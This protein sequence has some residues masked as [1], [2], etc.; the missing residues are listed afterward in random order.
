MSNAYKLTEIAKIIQ[1]KWLCKPKKEILITD[2]L[3]DSRKLAHTDKTLFFALTGQKLDGHSY[4]H[5]LYEKGVRAFVVSQPVQTEKF[6][7]A[8]VL[9]V[10]D[11]LTALQKLATHHRS[12]F[13]YPVIS[14]TGSNGKTIVKEWLYQLLH[15]DYRIVRSPKSYNSQIG[16]PLSLWN[17]S[18]SDTLGIFEAGISEPDEMSRLERMIR[19]TIGVFT[20]IGEAHSEGFLNIRHKTKEKLKLFAHADILIYCKDYTDIH[21]SIAEVNAMARSADTKDDII[22]TFTWSRIGDA[23][24]QV[25]GET[26]QNGK[27]TITARYKQ[28]LPLEFTIPFTDKASI[29]NAIH[30][31]AVM[32][33]L[34]ISPDEIARRMP[35]LTGIAMRLEMRDAINGC[36][37]IN[38]SY[39]SDINSLRIA[40][41]FLQQQTRHPRKTI[42]LS[43]I[44]QSGKSEPELYESVA[45]LLR[46]HTVHRFVGIGPAITRQRKTFENINGTEVRCYQTTE[47]FLSEVDFQEFQ[48]EA[49]LLK[50]ARKFRFEVLAKLLEKK[51]HETV[52]EI[53]LNAIAHNLKVYQSLLKPT[54]KIMAMVKAFSYGSG[55]HEIANVLQFNRCDYLAVAYTDEGVDLRKNGITLPIMVMNPEPNSFEQMIKYRLEPDIYSLSLLRRFEEAL[56]LLHQP[57]DAPYPVHIELETGMNRLGLAADDITALLEALKHNGHLRIA[58]VFTHLAASEDPHQDRFT[59][60]QIEQFETLS[61]IICKALNYSVLR[62]VLNSNGITRHADAQYDMVRLGIGLYGIDTSGK[63]SSKLMHVSTLKTTISQ[64]KHIRKGETV[65]YGRAGKAA[66]DK[67]IATV[68]IGYA[69]G[70]SRRLGNG[71]GYM[72]VNGHRAP[73]IGNVCMDMTMLDITGIPACEG[74]EVIVF[75]KEL[76]VTELAAAAQTIPYEILTGISPRVK[77]IYYQE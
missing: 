19:P 74:D 62:H 20:N 35:L 75:G 2:L 27:T 15:H 45:A 39:N 47:Q 50:G 71:N 28:S 4:L 13:S 58:S 60:A 23:D 31:A 5:E 56:Q 32:L 33:Y 63:I 36:T 49:I 18:E 67:T 43:D 21:L 52:L 26:Q 30:C 29:E 1:G 37:L 64:I 24:L 65:G 25:T 46:S 6:A 16:V 68:G 55:S 53:N 11:T 22:K 57:G 17:M 51:A 72:L 76:P 9:L 66:K 54:T 48:Q 61:G 70:Y 14:I 12:R 44:L 41:D 10:S 77:R 69:D 34:G 7:D 59:R 73:T 40:L 3:T 38:D 8:G 42:I